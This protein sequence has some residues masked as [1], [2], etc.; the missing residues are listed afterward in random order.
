L[1]RFAKR[2]TIWQ[3]PECGREVCLDALRWMS[4]APE[5]KFPELVSLPLVD[6]P[7]PAA[8]S[9]E[10]ASGPYPSRDANVVQVGPDRVV[11]AR[12]PFRLLS[13]PQSYVKY[14]LSFEPVSFITTIQ[15]RFRTREEHGKLFRVSDKHAREYGILEVCQII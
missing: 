15:L 11:T 7:H 4:F 10:A 2:F 14:A 6:R 12:K 8:V 1:Y 5:T 3:N 13:I 9:T